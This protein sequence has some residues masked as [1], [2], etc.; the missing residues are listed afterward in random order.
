[1]PSV[2][3]QEMFRLLP[4]LATQL[5]D[6]LGSG[7]GVGA[8]LGAAVYMD[9]LIGAREECERECGLVPGA[10]VGT[11]RRV[12]GWVYPTGA[13]F[14]TASDQGHEGGEEES[15]SGFG[16][17]DVDGGDG[18]LGLG[19]HDSMSDDDFERVTENYRSRLTRNDSVGVAID[20]RAV[21]R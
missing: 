19:T 4:G 16:D 11:G 6:E 9:L 21:L 5:I 18:G 2:G 12:S 7:K 14:A 1:M 20:P 17:A 3:C 8:G 15:G 13:G 10:A